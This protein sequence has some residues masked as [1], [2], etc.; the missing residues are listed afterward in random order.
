[1]KTVEQDVPVTWTPKASPIAAAPIS[2]SNP[3]SLRYIST[4]SLQD[5]VDISPS[6]C[7][8]TSSRS[9]R[10]PVELS[11]QT[12]AS[13]A[14]EGSAVAGSAPACDKAAGGDSAA[15]CWRLWSSTLRDESCV[16]GECMALVFV[17]GDG[18]S[19]GV[20]IL[21]DRTNQKV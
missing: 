14:L 7:R 1:M 4:S 5:E 21:P 11:T 10:T 12:V 20:F 18:E 15:G 8:Y 19:G 6:P 3:K 2:L 9:T 13:S 17:G 16:A